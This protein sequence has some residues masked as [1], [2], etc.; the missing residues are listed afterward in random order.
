MGAYLRGCFRP[1]SGLRKVRFRQSDWPRSTELGR[2]CA[3]PEAKYGGRPP[4]GR[5]APCL[6]ASRGT[7]SISSSVSQEGA[8]RASQVL[9]YFPGEGPPVP[10]DRGQEMRICK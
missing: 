9:T 7:E 3:A 2:K 6:R 5:V 8:Q 10:L 4:R 1:V